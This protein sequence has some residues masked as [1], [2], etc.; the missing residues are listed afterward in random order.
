MPRKI[1]TSQQSEDASQKGDKTPVGASDAATT[2]DPGQRD[3][4]SID[5]ANTLQKLQTKFVVRMNGTDHTVSIQ[6]IQGIW[7]K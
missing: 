7:K 4:D 3:N 1:T 5:T 2:I 6:M